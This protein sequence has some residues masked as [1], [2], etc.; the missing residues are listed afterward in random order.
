MHSDS[1]VVTA[2]VLQC[3]GDFITAGAITA[4]FNHA[5]RLGA[6]LDERLEELEIVGQRVQ[7]HFHD[8]HVL[9]G[10]K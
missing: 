7:V 1:E 9:L 3:L 10:F 2:A 8:G 6:G 5:H 4:R